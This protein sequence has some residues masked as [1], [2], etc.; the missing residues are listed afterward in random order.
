MEAIDVGTYQIS[1]GIKE[2]NLI[3]AKNFHKELAK[4]IRCLRQGKILLEFK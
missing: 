3:E 2:G 1:L 4:E